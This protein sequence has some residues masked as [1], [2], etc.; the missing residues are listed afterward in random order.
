MI[1]HKDWS[2]VVMLH[3]MMRLHRSLNVIFFNDASHMI[4]IPTHFS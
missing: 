2:L 3:L 1:L 4:N